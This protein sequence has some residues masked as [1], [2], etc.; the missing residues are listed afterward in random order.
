MIEITKIEKSIEYDSTRNQYFSAFR[1]YI[2]NNGKD[3]LLITDGKGDSSKIKNYFC[4]QFHHIKESQLDQIWDEIYQFVPDTSTLN[5]INELLQMYANINNL[6]GKEI[7]HNLAKVSISY[8]KN[9]VMLLIS[10]DDGKRYIFIFDK[11]LILDM[12]FY[13]RSEFYWCVADLSEFKRLCSEIFTFQLQRSKVAIFIFDC[14]NNYLRKY[15][16]D[17]TILDLVDE[18][19]QLANPDFNDI[20]IFKNEDDNEEDQEK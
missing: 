7:H 3:E 13:R 15:K 14:I 1:V 19:N 5:N 4:K 17:D 9:D 11:D 6:Y 12:N 8:N 20:D 16:F 18:F 2:R 10:V